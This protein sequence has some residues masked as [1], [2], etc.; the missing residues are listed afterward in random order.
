V[1]TLVAVGCLSIASRADEAVPPGKH[2]LRY[3]FAMG[4]VLRY[5]VSHATNVRTTIDNSTQQAETQSK[6]VKVWK[7]TD[8]LPNG[9]MEF[10]HL[11]ES[12]KM[13]NQ[14]PDRPANTYD[15]RTDAKPPRGF[16]QAARA[17]GVPLSLVRIAADGSVTHR[18][19][20]HP[21]PPASPD[22]PIT[23]ALPKEPIAVGE[24]WSQPYDVPAERQ[25]G[26]KLQVR[27]RRVCQLEQVKNGVATINVE[28]Q[29]LTPVDPFVRSQLV[30]RLTQGTVRFDV[31][32]GRI[33]DQ[34]HNVD[35]R[36]LGFAG[37]ASSMHFVARLT[38]RLLPEEKVAA[39]Q[40]ASA[41]EAR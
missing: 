27:T 1:L 36:I 20:K 34:E 37:K 32:R 17:V 9:E 5:D 33:I 7:V 14:V 13:S 16:E 21:Q 2:L 24:K 35:K 18:E 3:R 28:Y 40:Q 26:A 25:G 15:S 8:V 29:I 12:V 11:V 41:E 31:E 38:E 4:D 6:S 30:E 39:V 23:L 22:M 10:I 19:E